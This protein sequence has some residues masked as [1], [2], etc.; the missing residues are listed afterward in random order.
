MDL[1]RK[2]LKLNLLDQQTTKNVG[3]CYSEIEV[4]ISAG[5]VAVSTES[6]FCTPLW[7]RK[8]EALSDSNIPNKF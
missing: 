3:I 1:P 2:E 8:T 5:K 7:L 6:G 4:L